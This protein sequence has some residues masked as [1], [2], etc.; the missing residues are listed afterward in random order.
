MEEVLKRPFHTFVP[1]RGI[2][3]RDVN[4][5]ENQVETQVLHKILIQKEKKF[6]LSMEISQYS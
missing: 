2:P 5:R 1:A 4:T 3:Q 6:F